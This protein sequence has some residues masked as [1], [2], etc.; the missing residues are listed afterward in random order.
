MQ[1]GCIASAPASIN[2]VLINYFFDNNHT[3]GLSNILALH[4][5]SGI[6][7]F[8]KFQRPECTRLHLR[9]FFNLE[10]FREVYTVR[11][12]PGRYRANIATVYYI[13]RLPLSQNLLSAPVSGKVLIYCKFDN[14]HINPRKNSFS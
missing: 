13:S 5:Q 9:D 3:Y 11:G 10:N 6:Q 1:E 7:A 2:K 4:V 8:A 14:H 12:P